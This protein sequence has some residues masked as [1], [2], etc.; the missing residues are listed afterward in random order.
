MSKILFYWKHSECRLQHH[1]IIASASY[2]AVH[3]NQALAARLDVGECVRCYVE[4][5]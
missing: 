1:K 2:Y 4:H 3:S 5:A